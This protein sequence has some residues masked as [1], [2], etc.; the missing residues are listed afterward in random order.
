MPNRKKLRSNQAA[1]FTLLAT[2]ALPVMRAEALPAF[3]RQTGLVCADCHTAFPELT[4]L[5]RR[6]KLNG[7]TQE[8]GDTS[9][10]AHL[11]AMVQATYTHTDAG[12]SGGAAP[13]F[14]PNN[15]LV[16]QQTSIFYGGKI[17]DNLGAFVQTTYDDVQKR[18]HWDNTDIRYADHGNLFGHKLVW[19][20]TGN[21]NPGV[22]DVW[23][24]TPAWGFPYITSELAPT[25]ASATL[26]EGSPA[27]K[28]AG[29]GAYAYID[30][31]FYI[32]LTGYK[33]L[34]AGAQTTLGI[35]PAGESPI[36]GIAPYWRIA[37]EPH[38]GKHWLEVGTFG[39]HA[40]IIPNRENGFGTDSVTDTGVDMEYQYISDPSIITARANW[41][42]ETRTLH[43]SQ[44][45]G[46]ADNS[47]GLLHTFHISASYIYEQTISATGGYFSAT[48]NTDF[49]L[50]GTPNGSPNSN[51]WTFDL[52]YL[53]F[54]HGGPSFWPWLNARI[55]I[56]YTLYDKFNGGRFNFNGSGRNSSDNNTLLTYIWVAF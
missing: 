32:E 29:L 4:P 28:V 26:I 38:W 11:A 18:L 16:V 51:G 50:N 25:P 5:G 7:Y 40:D 34:S 9:F 35:N 48:G 13:H 19:G 8:G 15:N 12:Q 6:F 54:M 21:N 47:H 1:L 30:D 37:V 20:I 42:R 55:G 46:L 27:Q 44:A 36:D 22:Q 39:M 41:I 24:S 2:A 31:I 23:S 14:G 33:Y 45:L 17:V 53:P 10:P 3:A 52:A 49:T 43:A 56:Q